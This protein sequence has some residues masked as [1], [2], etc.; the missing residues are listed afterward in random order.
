MLVREVGE[1]AAA[2]LPAVLELLGRD[3]HGGD[4]AGRDQVDRHDHRGRGEQLAGV[5][6][7]PLQPLLGARPVG[8]DERHHAHPGLEPGQ[9]QHQQREGDHRRAEDVE[10]PGAAGG[11]RV[12]PPGHRLGLGEHL[13]D[14]DADDDRVEQQED[15]H[16]RDRHADRLAEP[17][18]EHPAQD[19]Q[20]H[21]RDRDLLPVQEPGEG[22]VLNHVQ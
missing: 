1:R 16:E 7:P 19:Q 5:A 17:E 14:A 3:E 4:E 21:D 8:G 2:G 15:R 9:A 18:Q 12:E 13:G 11:Q 10:H 22:R 6:D 20:Q